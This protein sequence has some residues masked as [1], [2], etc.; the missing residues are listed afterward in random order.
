MFKK[1]NIK[2]KELKDPTLRICHHFLAVNLFSR[3]DYTWKISVLEFFAL[4]C[5]KRVQKINLAFVL[6]Q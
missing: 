1:V 6:S 2:D 5:M 3:M 4:Y